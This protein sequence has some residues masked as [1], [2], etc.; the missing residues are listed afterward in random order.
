MIK[1]LQDG[2]IDM[3]ALEIGDIVDVSMLQKFQDNFAIGMDCASVTVD[4][5]GTCPSQAKL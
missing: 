5:N 3:K 4:R 2:T 1:L